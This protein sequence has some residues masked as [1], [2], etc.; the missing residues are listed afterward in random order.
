LTWA[1]PEDAVVVCTIEDPNNCSGS[2]TAGAELVVTVT[3]TPAVPVVTQNGNTLS[4]DAT[5]GIQWYLN[6]SPI[7]GATSSTYVPM[8][9]GDYS[10]VLSNGSCASA[11]SNAVTFTI[12]AIESSDAV[13]VKIYPNPVR[14]D[15]QLITPYQNGFDWKM[16]NALG[17]CIQQGHQSSANLQ[18]NVAHL[19]K[20]IYSCVVMGSE[21]T[22]KQFVVER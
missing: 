3:P 14:A 1:S 7:A 18:M 6:G 9:N 17:Q 5:M 20:G 8:A 15:L 12:T 11:M 13:E 10:V 4:V 22:V 21:I 19:E 16:Y 2:T